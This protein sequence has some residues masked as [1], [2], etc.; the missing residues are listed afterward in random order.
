MTNLDQFK[1]SLFSQ[2]ATG[3]LQGFGFCEYASPEHALRA[4]RLLHD[5]NVGEKKLVVKVDAKTKTTLDEYN[6]NRRKTA[7]GKSP[8]SEENVKED[9]MDDDIRRADKMTRDQVQIQ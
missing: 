9:F 2:G 7:T 1:K 3:K 8:T 4:I 5:F 6:K